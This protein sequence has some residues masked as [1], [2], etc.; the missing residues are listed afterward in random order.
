MRFEIKV[1]NG[2]VE[3]VGKHLDKFIKLCQDEYKQQIGGAEKK[4]MAKF[5]GLAHKVARNVS[6]IRPPDLPQELLMIQEVIDDTTIHLTNS[7]PIPKALARLGRVHIKMIKNLKGY[8]E[9]Q[10]FNVEVK[11]LGDN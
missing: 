9:A 11:Y 5:Y 1:A 3:K 2:N 10:G 7:M 8:L 4:T 6:P